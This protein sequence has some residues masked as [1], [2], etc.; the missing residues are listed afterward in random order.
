MHLKI[1]DAVTHESLADECRWSGC[2]S[3]C[4]IGCRYRS[5]CRGCY[6]CFVRLL[7]R[8]GCSQVF[9]FVFVFGRRF[10]VFFVFGGGGIS[11]SIALD[12]CLYFDFVFEI[13]LDLCL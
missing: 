12:L 1:L 7:T 5:G 11:A 9:V 2:R 6:R 3:G 8:C 10:G 13:A 4:R